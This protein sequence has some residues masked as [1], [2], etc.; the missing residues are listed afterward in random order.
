MLEGFVKRPDAAL[1]FTLRRCGVFDKNL[2]L[3][4]LRMREAVLYVK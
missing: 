2:L 4:G 1:R 3:H